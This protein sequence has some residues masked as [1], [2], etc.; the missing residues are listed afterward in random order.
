MAG[1]TE[2]QIMTAADFKLNMK[3]ALD[4]CDSGTTITLTRKGKVYEVRLV[5]S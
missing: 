5:A 4:A 3:Q 2:E 1:R